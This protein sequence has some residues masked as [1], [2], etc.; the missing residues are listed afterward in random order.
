[1]CGGGVIVPDGKGLRYAGKRQG[2]VALQD[3]GA[4][5][6]CLLPFSY[7]LSVEAIT[8]GV[9][10]FC[11]CAVGKLFNYSRPCAA[12]RWESRGRFDFRL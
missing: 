2:T 1:V 8:S 7:R 4:F 12:P 6:G 5:S 9:A 10:F 3:A 11:R